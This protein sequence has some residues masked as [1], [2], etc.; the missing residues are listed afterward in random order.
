M[1]YYYHRFHH[2]FTSNQTSNNLQ[3]LTNGR[4]L[5]CDDLQTLNLS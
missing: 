3:R 4:Q 2:C 1:F 5:L